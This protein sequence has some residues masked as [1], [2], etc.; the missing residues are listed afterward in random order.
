MSQAWA[1]ADVGAR[2]AKLQRIRERRV[3]P[4]NAFVDELRAR[5]GGTIPYLD[6]DWGGVDALIL[7][8]LL[9]PGPRAAESGFLSVENH[10]LSARY[11]LELLREACIS[12]EAA[13]VWNIVP[14]YGARSEPVSPDDLREGAGYLNRLLPMLPRLQSLVLVG[15][16]AQSVQSSLKLPSD[17]RVFRAPHTS[18]SNLHTNPAQREII[19]RAYMEAWAY[20]EEIAAAAS[21]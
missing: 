18:P 7:F 9:R 8:V 5:R 19:L 14:W 16:Q 4:L 10:D 6:P 1:M 17:V 3:A 12:I 20:A 15:R 13:A 11:M 2:E 21:S